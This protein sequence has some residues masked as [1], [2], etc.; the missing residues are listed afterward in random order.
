MTN[1]LEDLPNELLCFI[2]EY[3][4]LIDLFR[5]FSNL[6]QRFNNILRLVHFHFNVLYINRKQFNYFRH[7]ILPNI[8]SNWIESFYIDDIDDRLDAI[9]ICKNL[10]SLTIH[11]LRGENMNLL[12]ENILPK[13][14][15]LERLRL[16][17]DFTL[18]DSDV[19]LLTNVIFS[20]QM[21]SLIDCHLAFQDYSRMNLDHLDL[22]NKSLSLK[23]LVIDQWCRLRDFIRL[24]HFI[25]NINRLTLRLFDSH[26]K[27]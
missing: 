24:L 25:P 5:T 21:S 16:H 2:L 19:N 15:Y 8:E 17:S 9:H 6:N 13:L 18:R 10:R 23:T 11:H 3:I 26:F 14:N 22:R 1:R 7:T 4:P 27:R 20:E 12:A